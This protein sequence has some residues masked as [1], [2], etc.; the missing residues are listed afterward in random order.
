[1]KLLPLI[2]IQTHQHLTCVFSVK[3]KP[4]PSDSFLHKATA[5][6]NGLETF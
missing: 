5:I 3:T 2:E 1:M 6:G 4:D